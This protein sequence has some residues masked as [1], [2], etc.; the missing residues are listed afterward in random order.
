MIIRKLLL[1]YYLINKLNCNFKIALLICGIDK[2]YED[3]LIFVSL[4]YYF[5]FIKLIIIIG[6]NFNLKIVYNI[7]YKLF[8]KL[9]LNE[10]MSFTQYIIYINFIKNLL[11]CLV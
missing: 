7:N 8:K 1:Y 4:L 10:I 2:N 11:I 3:G 6:S 9:K 5:D